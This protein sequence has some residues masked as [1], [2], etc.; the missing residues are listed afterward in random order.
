[1]TRTA[2]G[3][4]ASLPARP[5]ACDRCGEAALVRVAVNAEQ[6]QCLD[7]CLRHFRVHQPALAA[8]RY[9]LEVPPAG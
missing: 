1:M 2:G 5:A 3:A 6:G 4:V 8:R 7:F 9:P